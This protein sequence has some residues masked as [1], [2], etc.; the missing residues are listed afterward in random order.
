MQYIYSRQYEEITNKVAKC[1]LHKMLP[2]Q[3]PVLGRIAPW[4]RTTACCSIQLRSTERSAWGVTKKRVVVG[5]GRGCDEVGGYVGRLVGI[6]WEF[7]E[8]SG[9]GMGIWC[10]GWV[11]GVGLWWYGVGIWCGDSPTEPRTT[12]LKKT[13]PRKTQPRMD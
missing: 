4:S 8:A 3:E 5:I 6:G 9:F 11:Y 12:E 10:G 13:E 7:G 1:R 2:K